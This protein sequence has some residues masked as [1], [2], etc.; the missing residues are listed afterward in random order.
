MFVQADAQQA[1]CSQSEQL[2][3]PQEQLALP[4]DQQYLSGGSQQQQQQQQQLFMPTMQAQPSNALPSTGKQQPLM[5][6]NTD[7]AMQTAPHQ[8]LPLEDAVSGS[9]PA[10]MEVD[11]SAQPETLPAQEL[12]STELTEQWH[13]RDT[14]A[15]GNSKL[16]SH[17]HA[18]GPV[19][20]AYRDEQLHSTAHVEQ[21]R[22]P[23]EE[24]DHLSVP[25]LA[26]QIQ[27]GSC[28]AEPPAG[29]QDQSWSGGSADQGASALLATAELESHSPQECRPK[30][31]EPTALNSTA[32]D[33]E[34]D[35]TGAQDDQALQPSAHGF[36]SQLGLHREESKAEHHCKP[37]EA[38]DSVPQSSGL[39]EANGHDWSMPQYP[40][41]RPDSLRSE[42]KHTDTVEDVQNV[43]KPTCWAGHLDLPLPEQELS[44]LEHA[45]V[46]KKRQISPS[47]GADAED[48]IHAKR[49]HVALSSSA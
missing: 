49:Q 35:G 40:I 44:Q 18:S 38:Q 45:P 23:A 13:L 37:P 2:A 48:T 31:E 26:H 9:S 4:T 24:H 7:E 42:G 22:Q 27:S 41:F 15:A 8:S 32:A 36:D 1:Y 10:A 19:G 16:V 20:S 47:E 3:Q 11:L 12:S 14:A 17:H 34:V 46:S 33:A 29:P 6:A 28:Y 39:A 25:T 5:P 43:A 21:Q 30:V